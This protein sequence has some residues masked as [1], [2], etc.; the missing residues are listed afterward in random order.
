M[1]TFLVH[2]RT[3]NQKKIA[4]LFLVKLGLTKANHWQNAEDA[5]E[6]RGEEERDADGSTAKILEARFG[7]RYPVNDW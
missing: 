3:K 4:S 2:Q 5:Q 1:I 7:W 6:N